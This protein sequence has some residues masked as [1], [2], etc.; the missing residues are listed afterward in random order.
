MAGGPPRP[1][2]AADEPHRMSS[3]LSISICKRIC[4]REENRKESKAGERVQ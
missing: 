3:R 2:R 1:A 4:K